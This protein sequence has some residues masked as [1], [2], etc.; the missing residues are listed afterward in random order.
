MDKIRLLVSAIAAITTANF[1]LTATAAEPRPDDRGN[2]RMTG[3]WTRWEV[4]PDPVGLNC[5]KGPGTEFDLV[6]AIEGKTILTVSPDYSPLIHNDPR[7]NPWLVVKVRNTNCFVRANSAFIRPA[8][9]NASTAPAAA[10][11]AAPQATA[12]MPQPTEAGNYINVGSWSRWQ[13]AN[14]QNGLNCRQ[15][16]GVEFPVV[17]AYDAGTVMNLSGDRTPAVQNDT[18][19]KPWLAVKVGN[20]NTCF[21]RSHRVFINP[22]P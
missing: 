6:A 22:I 11:A 19:Q 5:R 21:V 20:N 8:A 7:G 1:T 12:T 3:G 4:M 13:V 14:L 9:E 16:P 18:I 15:G 10:P 17:A 2:Y